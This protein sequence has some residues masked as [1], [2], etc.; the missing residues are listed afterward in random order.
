MYALIKR[1]GTPVNTHR[2]LVGKYDA[3]CQVL[4]GRVLLKCMLR[5]GQCGED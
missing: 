5:I 2:V 4:N 3:K 1:K